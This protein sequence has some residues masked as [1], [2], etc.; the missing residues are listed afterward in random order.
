MKIFNPYEETYPYINTWVIQEND[1][2]IGWD[3]E[4]RSLVRAYSFED[5]F[6]KSEEDVQ[7]LDQAFKALEEFLG[8]T[9]YS[10]AEDFTEDWKHSD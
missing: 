5:L 3:E 2:E 6:W 4:T 7:S 8:N 9:V 1:V 10:E